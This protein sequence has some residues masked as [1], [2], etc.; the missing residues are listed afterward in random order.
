VGEIF[1]R[2]GGDAAPVAK[3]IEQAVKGLDPTQVDTPSTIWDF[4]EVNATAMRALAR[5]VLFM[6]GIAVVL[7]ITGV[8]A[9]LTF[10]I[11]RRTR[12]FAIQMMLGA[13]RQSI[14]R[15]V[16]TKGLRQ[17]AIGLISGLILAVPAAWT[18]ENMTKRSLLPI[19][20]FDFSVYSISAIIL[21][22][23]SVCAMTIPGLRA[24][25]VDPMQALRSE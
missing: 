25:R 11:N 17:I 4:L 13:T 9:V 23:V 8:Y 20:A 7:A 18:F 14:F 1:V 10:V 12:E 22:L 5:I 15:S 24:T 6:A 19:H 16:L 21:L 2:F 3:G